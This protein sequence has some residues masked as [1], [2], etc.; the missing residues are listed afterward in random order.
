MLAAM[1]RAALAS[2]GHDIR[3]GG[4]GQLPKRHVTTNSAG[5]DDDRLANE[6][7]AIRGEP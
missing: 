2:W 1:R 3:K 7:M 6:E 4:R 5:L